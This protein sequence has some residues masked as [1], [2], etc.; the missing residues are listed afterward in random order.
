VVSLVISKVDVVFLLDL[1]VLI[2]VGI[3]CSLDGNCSLD[4]E[5][6]SGEYEAYKATVLIFGKS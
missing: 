3:G 1:L 2:N 4:V 5:D 6:V